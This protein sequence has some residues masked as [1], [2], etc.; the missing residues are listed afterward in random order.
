MPKKYMGSRFP[1][2]L[3]WL[4]KM[5]QYFWLMNYLVNIWADVVATHVMDSAQVWL[6]NPVQDIQLG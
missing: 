1:I 4:L 5:E 2:V 6:D 3:G